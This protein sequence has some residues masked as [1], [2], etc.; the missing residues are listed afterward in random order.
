MNLPSPIVLSINTH[1]GYDS[2]IDAQSGMRIIPT[3]KIPKKINTLIKVD[4]VP[5]GY[6]NPVDEKDIKKFMNIIKQQLK[7]NVENVANV[8]NADDI[9]VSHSNI[10]ILEKISKN[11]IHECKKMGQ[12][13]NK[14][15]PNVR[16]S[17]NIYYNKMY[18]IKKFNSMDKIMNKIFCYSKD[19]KNILIKNISILNEGYENVELF[20]ILDK[21]FLCDKYEDGL[22]I[23][24]KNI[25][26]FL[27]K[28]NVKKVI[29]YD[30][31]CFGI[32]PE[33]VFTPRHLRKIRRE[34]LQSNNWITNKKRSYDEI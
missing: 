3:I 6:G 1:G 4:S 15:K 24:L 14:K 11:I 25:L 2:T 8:A 17:K 29:I 34:E 22:Q 21:N 10:K 7:I 28:Q 20:E 16:F 33:E 26:I 27:A 32:V 12:I 30:F 9:D 31:T 23:S 5:I 13:K 19:E 18:Q